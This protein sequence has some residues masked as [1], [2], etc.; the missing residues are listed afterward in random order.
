MLGSILSGLGRVASSAVNLIPGI[1][2]SI[3][4]RQ[5]DISSA[6]VLLVLQHLYILL[7]I[8]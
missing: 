6:R 2:S 8:I 3:L 5:M 1:G 4:G 7:W